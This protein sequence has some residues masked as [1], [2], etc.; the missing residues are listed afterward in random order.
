MSILQKN[1]SAISIALFCYTFAITSNSIF[2]IP[3]KEIF[4]A[5]VVGICLLNFAK[6]KVYISK[7]SIYVLFVLLV[8][9]TIWGL[10]GI[11]NGFNT[12]IVQQSLKIITCVGIYE[13][14]CY[15]LVNRII[16]IS[17]L[18]K[19][20]RQTFYLAIFFKLFLEA[21]YV[22][23]I[24]DEATLIN[25]IKDTFSMDVM[26]MSINDGMLIRLGLIIDV[27]PL[28]IFPLI[29]LDANK[30]EKLFIWLAI[31][32]CLIINFSRIYILQFCIIVLIYNIDLFK[33]NKVRIK[34]IIQI[35]FITILSATILII[36]SSSL[37][38][39]F[40]DR[41]IGDSADVS[42]I[43]RIE[44]ISSFS[45]EIPDNLLLGK[46]LGSYV[47]Y[48]IRSDTMPFL[49]ELEYLALLFQFGLIGCL[50][51]ASLFF[52]FIKRWEISSLNNNKLKWIIYVNLL[53]F[54]LRPIFNPMLFASNTIIVLVCFMIYTFDTIQNKEKRGI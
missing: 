23:R 15:I 3:V 8:L 12:S 18:K 25:L 16:N 53:F 45:R 19:I 2:N 20:I 10:I 7:Y 14:F 4:F 44:Q 46:G 36:F 32:I 49:Y 31:I 50:I 48:N 37:I 1:F 43:A 34:S 42:D 28:S 13:C 52:F 30:K 24:C 27:L 21:L 38:N 54:F 29:L 41:F 9:L 6:G 47:P 39:M 5:L 35:S 40:S 51:I 22:F 33:I 26:P 11:I 17:T